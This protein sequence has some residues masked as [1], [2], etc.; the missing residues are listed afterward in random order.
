MKEKYILQHSV[1]K[2][3][4]YD[5]LLAS[6]KRHVCFNKSLRELSVQLMSVFYRKLAPQKQLYGGCRK[7]LA[8]IHPGEVLLV[9][10]KQFLESVCLWDQLSLRG[11]ES[12]RVESRWISL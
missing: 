9:S 4:P 6:Q 2:S 5:V 11:S 10:V 1:V 12:S 8:S 7:V 3:C